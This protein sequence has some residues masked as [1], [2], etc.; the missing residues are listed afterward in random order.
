MNCRRGKE[1]TITVNARPT[2]DDETTAD[3]DESDTG[4]VDS[5][6]TLYDDKGGMIDQND[7]EDGSKG[8]LNSVLKV[9]PEADAVYFIAVSA[10]TT[11]PGV[12][13]DGAYTV[14]V[15]ER[16]VGPADIPGTPND[17]KLNG[18]DGGE[19]IAGEGR[20]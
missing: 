13:Y 1:Y 6:L 11:N 4:L 20:Q 12:M 8:K 15:M 14:M 3:V 18:T 7:D 9:T 17:D 5:V 2:A 16:V 10:N 19:K